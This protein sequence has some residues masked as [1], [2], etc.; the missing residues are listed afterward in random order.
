[1]DD[2][3]IYLKRGVTL[4]HLHPSMLATIATV[5]AIYTEANQKLTITSATEGKHRPNSRHYKGL[6]LDIRT[7][8]LTGVTPNHMARLLRI[9]LPHAKVILEDTHIHIGHYDET[10]TSI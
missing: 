9:A 5:H 2:S 4:D 6:A 10:Q 1:M 7:R 3:A 8:D